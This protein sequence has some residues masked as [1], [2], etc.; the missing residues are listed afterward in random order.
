VLKNVIIT[1]KE[2]LEKCTEKELNSV[3]V[4]KKVQLLAEVNKAANMRLEENV[5]T[6]VEVR[7]RKS[8]PF[9]NLSK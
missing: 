8:V 4:A 6:A 7:T 1:V 3:S 2:K 9:E 5:L